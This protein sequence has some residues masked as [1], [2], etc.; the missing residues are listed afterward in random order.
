MPRP[1]EI[2]KPAL[3]LICADMRPVG[4]GRLGHE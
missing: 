3:W 1:P 4:I 2:D